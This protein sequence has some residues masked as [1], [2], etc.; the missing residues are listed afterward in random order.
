MVP[1]PL[2]DVA[3]IW[4]TCACL[5]MPKTD[6]A[7]ISLNTEVHDLKTCPAAFHRTL[8][9]LCSV[10]VSHVKRDP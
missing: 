7:R 9:F 4:N 3:H 8:A 5:H 6:P 1:C 2:T 10:A